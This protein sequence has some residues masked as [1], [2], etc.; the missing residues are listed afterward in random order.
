MR[1]FLFILLFCP[2]FLFAQNKL[3]NASF[4]KKENHDDCHDDA[5]PNDL[6]W[7]GCLDEWEDRNG[8]ANGPEPDNGTDYHS[9]DWYS[10]E[11]Y[12]DGQG[13]SVSHLKLDERLSPDPLDNTWTPINAHSGTDYIGM[14]CCE[15]TQQPLGNCSNLFGNPENCLDAGE[16]YTVAMYIRTLGNSTS[17]SPISPLDYNDAYLNVY[18][19]TNKIRYL[20][21]GDC[22]HKTGI[23]DWGQDIQLVTSFKI[24]RTLYPIGDWHF[25]WGTFIAP[26]DAYSAAHNWFAI[27]LV[28][29]SGDCSSYVLIDDISLM[30]CKPSCSRTSGEMW[31]N[32]VNNPHT[33]NNPF[34]ITNLYNVSNVNFKVWNYMDQ[35]LVKEYN[36]SSVNGFQE[37]VYWNGKNENGDE[38]AAGLYEAEITLTNDCGTRMF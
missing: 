12:I 20:N 31:A 5:I 30:K 6:G 28:Q 3:G 36:F 8:G 38:V 32:Q 23:N 33:E 2:I 17:P 18:L 34:G 25:I 35:V 14:R 11:L 26:N 21:D 37:S 15:L 16:E 29:N 9:P 7:A 10:H 13:Y 24:D 1:V 19:A 22:E 4:E 27:E